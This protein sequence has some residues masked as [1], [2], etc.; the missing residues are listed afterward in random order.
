MLKFIQEYK[1]KRSQLKSL[2]AIIRL[3]GITYEEYQ[4]LL[5]IG[6][7]VGVSKYSIETMLSRT[8]KVKSSQPITEIGK[9]DYIYDIAVMAL[10]D[11]VLDEDDI[12]YTI[13]ISE[14]L[15]ISKSIVG[16]LVRS[17]FLL[18]DENKS[19]IDVIQKLKNHL[20][21]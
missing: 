4:Y 13:S 3:D 1:K 11:G 18:V 19:K 9:I 2:V 7:N 16:V 20:L 10:V 5:S 17:I 14:K 8:K 12:E 6:L 15:G 21:I